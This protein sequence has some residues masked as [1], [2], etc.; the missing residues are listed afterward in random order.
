MPTALLWT[1]GIKPSTFCVT[2]VNGHPSHHTIPPHWCHFVFC[3]TGRA[4]A[5]CV[6]CAR[7]GGGGVQSGRVC[8]GTGDWDGADP[9]RGVPAAGRV[10]GAGRGPLHQLPAGTHRGSHLHLV[11]SHGKVRQR[12]QTFQICPLTDFS[13]S[14]ACRVMAIV[15]F[16][17]W[18]PW[19]GAL[20][21]D[22]GNINNKETRH[23]SPTFRIA[24]LSFCFFV[25]V[26]GQWF[27]WHHSALL[28]LD[29]RD[30]PPH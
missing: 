7:G 22:S 23:G 29:H 18:I 6:L 2:T 9:P 16:M 21:A 10:Q 8:E 14:Q 24:V 11:Q 26:L 4:G 12:C 13:K 27:W 17:S 25:Q 5:V 20:H 1:L 28:G 15:V 3:L 30:A 19:L